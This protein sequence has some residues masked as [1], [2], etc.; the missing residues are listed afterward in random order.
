[1]ETVLTKAGDF[2]A[3]KR[4]GHASAFSICNRL[5][6]QVCTVSRCVLALIVSLLAISS[7]VPTTARAED[8]PNRPIRVVVQTTP[9]GTLDFLGRLISQKLGQSWSHGLVVENRGGAGGVIGAAAVANAAPDGYTVGVFAT[10]LTVSASVDKSMPYSA[11]LRDFAPVCLLGYGTWALVVNPSLPVHSVADLIKLAKKEPGKIDFGSSG[12]GGAIHLALE[13]FKNMAGVDVVH[14]PYPGTN[15]AVTDVMAGRIAFT[16]TGLQG[17]LPLEQAG[18]LRIIAV[19]GSHRSAAVP[20]IPT[21]G[22][23]VPGYSFDNWYGIFAPRS[24]PSPV[25]QKLHD[26]IQAVLKEDDVQQKLKAQGFE[27]VDITPAE[28]EKI[29]QKELATYTALAKKIGL[30]PN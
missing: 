20:N 15:Q 21:I 28:F 4:C 5:R 24:T 23:T 16:L 29:V 18:K 26:S 8:Y 19:T 14:I 13:M 6:V 10:M 9:G 30:R 3:P 7:L 2:F 22:E 25:I 1:M 11:S 12:A 27:T 17:A